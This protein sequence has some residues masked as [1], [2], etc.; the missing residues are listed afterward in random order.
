MPP[1]IFLVELNV[2][3]SED[4]DSRLPVPVHHVAAQN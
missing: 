1:K 3:L 2:I 4:F